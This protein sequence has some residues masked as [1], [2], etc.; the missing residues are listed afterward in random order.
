VIAVVCLFVALLGPLE[1]TAADRLVSAEF[2]L[3]GVLWLSFGAGTF[4]GNA[5]HPFAPVFRALIRPRLHG[6]AEFEDARPPR[7]A[8]LVGFVLSTVGLILHVAGVPFGLVT[9]TALIVVASFLQAFVGFCLG[10]W[11]YLLLVRAGAH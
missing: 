7:F 6:R 3:L 8:L 10:C 1:A 2:L 11:M 4:F 9:A 5:A